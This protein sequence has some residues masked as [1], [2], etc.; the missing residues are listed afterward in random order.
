MDQWM[1][2]TGIL[3][4]EVMLFFICCFAVWAQSTTDFGEMALIPAGPFTMGC[5]A[6][7]TLCKS[8]EMPAKKVHI[9]AFYMDVQE[10]TVNE[11]AKCVSAG[12]C[13][14]PW[15]EKKGIFKDLYTWGVAGRENHPINGVEWTDAVNYCKFAGKR[16][17]TEAEFEKALRGGMEGNIYPWG[18]TLPSK[19]KVGNIADETLKK[20]QPKR[21]IT[22]G[23]DDGFAQTAPVC[24]LGKNPYGLCDIVGN[25]KEWCQDYYQA[26][27][28]K[29]MPEK[30][31][32]NTKPSDKR[33]ARGPSW[34]SY[35]KRMRASGRHC[36]WPNSWNYNI[37][38]RCAKSK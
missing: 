19:E 2:R 14:E 35:P 5:V 37:G 9:D 3:F 13:K 24:S 8:D 22:P 29:N 38:I 18:N 28:Y 36:L 26:D 25:V 31:P 15:V 27:F 21:T 7:D 4:V 12:I 17:P 11:Y 33:T 20:A 10:V 34:A 23:Y 32:V 1:K 30:N 16:L 6:G